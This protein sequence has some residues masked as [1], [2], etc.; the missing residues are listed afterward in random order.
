MN[1][2]FG[3]STIDA[4]PSLSG[5]TGAGAGGV[6]VN[7]AATRDKV[8]ME[9]GITLEDS[10]TEPKEFVASMTLNQETP[11]KE[12]LEEQKHIKL[13]M[14]QN[15]KLMLMLETSISGKGDEAGSKLRGGSKE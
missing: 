15:I 4:M 2:G 8:W 1:K 14:A 10:L 11:M 7:G 9:Y 13:M 6:L 5:G 3:G 12:L